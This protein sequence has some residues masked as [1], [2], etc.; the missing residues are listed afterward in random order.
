M[1]LYEI[2][3]KSISNRYFMIELKIIPTGKLSN[4]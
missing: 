1:Q 4:N 3:T 2:A